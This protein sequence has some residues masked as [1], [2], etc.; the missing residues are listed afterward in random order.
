[1]SYM[2]QPIRRLEDHRL[3]TGESS[4][5]DDINLPD[6]LHAA[7]VRSPHAH[8]LIRSIDTSAA[9]GIEGVVAVLTGEDIEGELRNIPTRAMEG[10]WSVDEFNAPEQPALAQG[11]VFYVGQVVAVVVAENRYLAR[12]AAALV[13]VD[14]EPLKPIIDPL[15]SAREDAI[16]IHTELG[17]NI[18]LRLHHDRQGADLDTAFARADRVIRQRYEVQRLAPVP[19]EPR[20]SVASYQRDEDLL[21]VWASTQ[22]PH[23]VR[24]QLASLLGRPESSVRV[25]APDVGGGFGEK[26]GVFPEDLA[27]AYL[28]CSLGRPIKWVADRQDNML[29]FHGRG[30][31]VDIEAAVRNDGTI[32]GIRLKLVGDAGAF[33]V[34]STA[35]PPYR[36]SHRIIGPYSTPAARIEVLGVVTNK[37]PTGAYRGAGGP[38]SA[39]CME[40]TVDLIARELNL[41]PAE[42][43]RKNLIPPDAF[44]YETPTGLFYDSGAYEQSLDRALELADYAGWRKKAAESKEGNGPLIGVGLATVIKMSG[45]S[46]NARS[47][48]AWIS[49]EPT[50]RITALTG[51]SPHGQGTETSFAQ[52]VADGLGVTPQDVQVLHGDTAVVP[53][54][55]GTGSTRATV[56]GGSA[57]YEACQ[58][59]RGKLSL[60]AS[61]ILKCPAVDVGFEEGRAFDKNTPDNGISFAE[62]AAAAYDEDLLPPGMEAGLEFIGD[63]RLGGPHQNPHSFGAH[64]VVVEVSRDTGDVKII[65]YVAVH[66]CGRI[67]NPMLVEGQVHG[68]VA[69]GIGQALWEGMVYD[70]GGQ[71]LTGSLM[72]YALPTAAGMPELITDTMETPSPMNPLGIKGV[73]ELP[74]VA[75]PAAVANAVMDALSHTGVRHIDT[76]L[77][78]EKVWRALQEGI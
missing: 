41:D 57:L 17:T 23:G 13:Q 6:M 40:R 28:S 4:Y 35:G 42:V 52:I 47:E 77:T 3:L 33:F 66:D 21:T 56:V 5:V 70:E 51:V 65:R 49:I 11:K 22:S 75:A 8:A 73:G 62:V 71:P 54:G 10:E 30:H 45:G 24:R 61:H 59:A 72:D 46:D 78:R 60:I 26:G 29:G 63:F 39:F 74:T 12:D 32:L 7:I 44:P 37:P 2:G 76:P 16:P 67:I 69:Q 1:M 18:A 36:A 38:E 20:G 19:M 9:R 31:S 50:G 43:R 55:G 15:E 34:G 25:V 27:V 53:S 48:K 68:A 64:V 58:L 14:Y